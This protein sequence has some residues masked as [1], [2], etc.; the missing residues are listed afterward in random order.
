MFTK[1][2]TCGVFP[3][4]PTAKFPTEIM[5]ISKICCLIIPMLKKNFYI[6]L[7]FCILG[8]MEQEIFLKTSLLLIYKKYM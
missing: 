2:S 7:L 6:A 5:G 1:C 8:R 4:P 3:V